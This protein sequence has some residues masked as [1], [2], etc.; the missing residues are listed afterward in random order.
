MQGVAAGGY[1]SCI[2]EGFPW[3]F[4]RCHGRVADGGGLALHREELLC[5]LPTWLVG[6][7][8]E[9]L[10]DERRSM[11]KFCVVGIQDV[12]EEQRVVVLEITHP[13]APERVSLLSRDPG[14]QVPRGRCLSCCQRGRPYPKHILVHGA[15]KGSCTGTAAGVAFPNLRNE[16]A[17]ALL[18]KPPPG[19]GGGGGGHTITKT[20]NHE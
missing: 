18:V 1:S 13:D 14:D 15:G 8:G 12:F 2:G 11:G 20:N 4:N 17:G 7:E 3:F 10:E 6:E 19:G 5:D 16:R 9:V